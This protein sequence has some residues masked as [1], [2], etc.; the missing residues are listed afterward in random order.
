MIASSFP[1]TITSIFSCINLIIFLQPHLPSI[2]IQSKQQFHKQHNEQIK[3]ITIF[4]FQTHPNRPYPNQPPQPSKSSSPPLISTAK[5]PTRG[6]SQ[7]QLPL[8]AL[9]KQALTVSFPSPNKAS[10]KFAIALNQSL[11]FTNTAK[12]FLYSTTRPIWRY[13]ILQNT[14]DIIPSHSI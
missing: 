9:Q 7:K 8:F 4:V 5:H 2:H 6:R 12:K 14:K 13:I 11:N 3:H 10:T 1:F